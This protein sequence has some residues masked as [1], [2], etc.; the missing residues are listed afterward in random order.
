MITEAHRCAA[1]Q[2]GGMSLTVTVMD[3]TEGDARHYVP[4]CISATGGMDDLDA[5]NSKVRARQ[6]CTGQGTSDTS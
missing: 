4:R 6:V 5:I 1:V 2:A 3:F